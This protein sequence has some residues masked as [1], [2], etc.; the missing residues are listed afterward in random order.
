[1]LD[2]RIWERDF[3]RNVGSPLPIYAASNLN[4]RRSD[5]FMLHIYTKLLNITKNYVAGELQRSIQSLCYGSDDSLRLPEGAQ[6]FPLL[7]NVQ[8]WS[9]AHPA[10]HSVTVR[11]GR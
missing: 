2:P 8:T 3:P 4:D 11:G 6:T 7:Q 5:K 9:E 1:M 10:N